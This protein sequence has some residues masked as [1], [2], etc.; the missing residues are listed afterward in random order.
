MYGKKLYCVIKLVFGKSIALH[1]LS[2]PKSQTPKRGLKNSNSLVILDL[3]VFMGGGV[4][5]SASGNPL[6]RLMPL[7]STILHLYRPRPQ[8]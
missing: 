8:P 7:S 6:D 2:E 1:R 4:V 5:V 3:Q